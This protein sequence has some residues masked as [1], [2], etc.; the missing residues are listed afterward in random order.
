LQFFKVVSKQLLLGQSVQQTAAELVFRRVDARVL[1]LMGMLSYES[2]TRGFH[3]KA[4]VALAK[5]TNED[6]NLS[7]L[8]FIG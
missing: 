1:P 4:E 5:L 3:K 6:E 7:F 8:R 2:K